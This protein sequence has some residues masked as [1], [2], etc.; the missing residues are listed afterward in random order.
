MGR[1]HRWAYEG[2]LVSAR[3]GDGSSAFPIRLSTFQ[4]PHPRSTTTSTSSISTVWP[5]TSVMSD[6]ALHVPSVFENLAV[7]HHE[8]DVPQGSDVRQGIAADGNDIRPV[9]GPDCSDSV[10]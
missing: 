5:T 2:R 1:R 3:K 4:R 10:A 9:A 6:C 8:R 7:L